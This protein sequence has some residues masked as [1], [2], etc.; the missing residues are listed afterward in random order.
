MYCYRWSWLTVVELSIEAEGF[1][2][3]FKQH[4]KQESKDNQRLDRKVFSDKKVK[5]YVVA[6]IEVIIEKYGIVHL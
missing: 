6:M 2:S 5:K 1:I 4:G 3:W